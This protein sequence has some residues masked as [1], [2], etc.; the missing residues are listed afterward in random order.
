MVALAA[1]EAREERAQVSDAEPDDFIGGGWLGHGSP[2]LVGRAEKA[3]GEARPEKVKW[4]VDLE[5]NL[6]RHGCAQRLLKSTG[7]WWRALSD[8]RPSPS[9]EMLFPRRGPWKGP[10]RGQ[11]APNPNE[12]KIT[13]VNNSQPAQ[14]ANLRRKNAP[15]PERDG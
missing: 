15:N 7:F 6:P 12:Q 9:E 14:K 10:Q 5:P 8:S 1:A 11:T 3:R 2:F 4:D 13:A